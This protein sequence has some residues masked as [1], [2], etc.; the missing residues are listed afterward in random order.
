MQ[1]SY[2]VQSNHYKYGSRHVL[3][4]SILSHSRI[5]DGMSSEE[6]EEEE[7]GEPNNSHPVVMMIEMIMPSIVIQEST[8]EDEYVPNSFSVDGTALTMTLPPDTNRTVQSFRRQR[9]FHQLYWD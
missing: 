7:E 1:K 2:T 9:R 8:G 6:D 4:K 3:E 5:S